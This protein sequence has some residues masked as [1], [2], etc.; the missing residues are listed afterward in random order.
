M[1]R[2]AKKENTVITVA[3]GKGGVGKTNISLNLALCLLNGGRRV[4]L[5]D[6]DI[7]AANVDVLLGLYPDRSLM[8]FLETDCALTDVML[9]GPGALRIV[10][11]GSALGRLA[12]LRDE[13]RGRLAEALRYL[14]GYDALVIDAP[15]GISDLV[16]RLLAVASVPIIVI[17]PEPTS[18]TDAYSLLK[19]C[20]QQ[21]LGGPAFIVVNQAKSAKHAHKVYQKFEQAVQKFLQLPIEP[22]G[23]I[24]SDSHVPEAVSKQ[25]PI[26][27]LFPDSPASVCLRR[28]AASV[29]SHQDRLAG[30]GALETLFG[31]EP[32]DPET[33]DTKNESEPQQSGGAKKPA[34]PAS[35]ATQSSS[36]IVGLLIKEGD[37]SDAQAEY[38]RKVQE[39]LDNPKRLLDVLKDLGYVQEGQVREALF[40]NRTGIRLGSL[41]MELGYITEKQ[42][43]ASLNQQAQGG[44]KKRLGEI[45]IE[46]NHITEYDLAQVL[47]MNFGISYLEPKLDMLDF[48]L[49]EKA[50]Q[51]FFQSHLLLPL[52]VQ[53]G[54]TK[55]VMAD[56]LDKSAL[57]AAEHLF[58][59]HISPS[60]TMRRF[61]SDALEAYDAF[62]HNKPRIESE[63]SEVTEV[64]DRL[65]QEALDKQ[66][67]DIHIEPLK[68]R[69]R[70]RLRRD[71][72]LIHHTDISK[73]LESALISRIKVMASA[74][75]TEKRRH[76]DGRILLGSAENGGEVDIRVSFYV[77]LFGEKVV[78]RILNKKP[79][80]YRIKDLGMGSK[81]LTRFKED[82]LDLPSGVVIITGPTGAGKTTTLY[83]SINYANNPDTNIITAEEPVEYVIEGISQCSIDQKIGLTFEETLRHMLRQDPDIIILGEIRDKFSAESAI[84]A[85]LTGHKVLT[86]FHTEDSIGGLLRLMNMDIETFLISS[87][88]VSVVAQRLLKK[89][90]PHCRKDYAPSAKDLR[91]LRYAPESIKGYGF[92]IGGGCQRCDYTGYLGRTGVFELLVLNEFIK[93][94][95][96]QR[97]TSYEIR[98]ISI[99][100]TGLVTLLED[101]LAKAAK[102]ITS[103]P[104][105]IKQLPLLEAPRPLDQI[106][107][108]IGDI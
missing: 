61:I 35:A 25:D 4:C 59:P 16:M 44:K 12:E 107:R 33:G 93:E 60:I 1:Q 45:L 105:V 50:S 66:A 28:I 46:N 62:K 49:M 41:L 71:G 102:G 57:E 56:P 64:A 77:T 51:Q 40:K 89:V 106:Y 21:D 34:W 10:P 22:L 42:L 84:Q 103:I 85:A 8:D 94:A 92:Q 24:L 43:N 53:D 67:S 65:I 54:E 37:I 83:A 81:T 101:G 63:K 88:V 15:A 87:T 3:S 38:A 13:E 48:G 47:S 68:N 29:V 18:L 55:I 95:I 52:G 74:D 108:I 27:D 91:Q 58:G 23:Y 36:E 9:E 30:P 80:L 26:V 82:V 86:T 90:C 98:R 32:S 14:E 20:H 17:V 70:V 72:S 5:L 6:A 104:E 79:E 31:P 39:K 73:D 100:T 75:I 76:Q 19:A 7:G 2:A 78:M 99:E 96:L 97:K 69:L 11:G